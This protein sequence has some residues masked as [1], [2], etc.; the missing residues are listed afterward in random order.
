[1]LGINF[2]VQFLFFSFK[3]STKLVFLAVKS[4]PRFSLC[5]RALSRKILRFFASGSILAH[6]ANAQMQLVMFLNCRAVPYHVL[7]VHCIVQLSTYKDLY[8]QG[9]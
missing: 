4:R 6:D 5:G 9:L 7:N 1:M 8:F 3:K 2:I